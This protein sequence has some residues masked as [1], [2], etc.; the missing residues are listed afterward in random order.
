MK[1]IRLMWLYRREHRLSRELSKFAFNRLS[2]R[3]M[4]RRWVPL[5]QVRQKIRKLEGTEL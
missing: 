5:E 1:Q 4:Y 2:S 3:R